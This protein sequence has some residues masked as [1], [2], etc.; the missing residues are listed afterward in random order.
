MLRMS[1][2]AIIKHS[3]YKMVAL[4]TAMG[5]PLSWTSQI[6]ATVPPTFTMGADDAMPA[7]YKSASLGTSGTYHPRG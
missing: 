1:I 7:I 2:M 4:N 6:S 3:T 5:R